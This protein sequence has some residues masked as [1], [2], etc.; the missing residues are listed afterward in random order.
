MTISKST[1]VGKVELANDKS[2]FSQ[3]I[4]VAAA[5]SVQLSDAKS[6]NGP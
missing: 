1:L 4:R 6:V 2:R 5:G 3:H